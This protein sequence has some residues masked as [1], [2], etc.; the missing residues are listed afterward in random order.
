MRASGVARAS[1]APRRT[2]SR[3]ESRALG[4][5]PKD[6][7]GWDSPPKRGARAAKA[8]LVSSRSESSLR[9]SR[10]FPVKPS[11]ENGLS[12]WGDSRQRAR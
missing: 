6:A 8:S 1:L 11:Q 3:A 12:A 7:A 5:S 9:M 2:S 10:S 4:S